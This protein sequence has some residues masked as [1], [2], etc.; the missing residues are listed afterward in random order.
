MQRATMLLSPLQPFTTRAGHPAC[1]QLGQ[2]NMP[3]PTGQLS[4]VL[5]QQFKQMS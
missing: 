1:L 3:C 4:A 5:N 2:Q